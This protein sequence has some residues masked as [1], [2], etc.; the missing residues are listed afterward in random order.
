MIIDKDDFDRLKHL[1][2]LM[3]DAQK[4]SAEPFPNI[5]P[6]PPL[7]AEPA[8]LA[9]DVKEPNLPPPPPP[10]KKAP[11]ALKNKMPNV[12][13]PPPPIPENATEEQRQKYMEA[14]RRYK[15]SV[16]KAAMAEK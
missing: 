3:S 14:T 12:P 5:P 1:Y 6:P 2:G 8:P 7:P 13:P 9:K 10:A 16:E 15:L 11:K 4:R